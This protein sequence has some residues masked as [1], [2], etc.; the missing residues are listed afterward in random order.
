MSVP[1]GI[2]V[3]SN[4]PC[5]PIGTQLHFQPCGDADAHQTLHLVGEEGALQRVE[6]FGHRY[7]QQAI[8]EG[9]GC[10]PPER[11]LHRALQAAAD[12]TVFRAHDLQ[13]LDFS[14]SN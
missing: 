5:Q 13:F 6:Y 10:M 7:A 3:R 4:D 1:V 12:L 9:Q 2:Q 11:E 8:F 14:G